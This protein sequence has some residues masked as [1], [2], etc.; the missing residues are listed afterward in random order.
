[1]VLYFT[2]DAGGKI[3]H[4]QMNIQLANNKQNVML[5]AL[6]AKWQPRSRAML[7]QVRKKVCVR[8]SL[9]HCYSFWKLKWVINL[10]GAY[11]GLLCAKKFT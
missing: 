9:L 6:R 4:A 10:L 11:D 5:N 3:R 8:C 1:M 2:S 7:S